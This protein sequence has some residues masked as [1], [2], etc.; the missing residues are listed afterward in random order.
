MAELST[1]VPVVTRP[2]R[3]E[4]APAIIALIGGVYGEYP[5]CVLDLPGVDDDLVAPATSFAR[6]GARLWVV[7]DEPGI[8]ATV[9][10]GPLTEDGTVELKRLYV[11]GRARRRGLG[12]SLVRLVEREAVAVGATAVELWS[13]SRF[14]DAHRLYERLGYADSGARRELGDPSG[15]TERHFTR[16]LVHGRR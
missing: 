3:D 15:T 4:D 5:G 14:T 12:A 7:D 11:A 6:A 1:N 13:D 8:V 9:G 10:V 2:V 16:S